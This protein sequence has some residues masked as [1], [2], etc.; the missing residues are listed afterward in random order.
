MMSSRVSRS[1]PALLVVA[2]HIIVIYGL[3]VTMGFVKVPS[4]IKP[5]TVVFVPEATEE[6][7]SE[8]VDLPKPDIAEPELTVPAPEVMPELPMEATPIEAKATPADGSTAPI[9]SLQELRATSRAEPVYPA[10]SRRLGEQGSVI[11]RVFVD[12]SGRPQQVVVD[13]SSG[14]TR[15]DDAAATAVKRWRFQPA[16]N[17]SGPVASWSRVTVTFRLQ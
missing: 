13:R 6:Q 15:L 14:H 11:L 2:L 4:I 3:S 9:G 16:S 12:P 17:G 8:P 7:K 1:G 5:A 10:T